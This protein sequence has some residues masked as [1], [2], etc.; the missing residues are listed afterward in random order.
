[1][2]ASSRPERSLAPC[3][4]SSR[5][6]LSSPEL[7]ARQAR[8]PALTTAARGAFLRSGRDEETAAFGRTKKL[9][10][11][12]DR[13]ALRQSL[14]SPNQPELSPIYPVQS[15]TYLSVGQDKA[16][17]ASSSSPDERSETGEGDRPQ[18]GGGGRHRTSRRFAE[19][20]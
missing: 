2:T 14:R 9:T 18:G 11:P 6:G 5:R 4:R 17:R 10:G 8:R 12:G 1:M 3:S 13:H 16:C 20:S 7:A 19:F 15:A